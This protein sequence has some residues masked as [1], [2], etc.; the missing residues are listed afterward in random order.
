MADAASLSAGA[1]TGERL[2]ECTDWRPESAFFGRGKAEWG[3]QDGCNLL[4]REGYWYWEAERARD[5][6][7]SWTE[8]GDGRRRGV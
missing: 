3:L 6:V 5:T 1:V 2:E 8:V 7:E 4:L